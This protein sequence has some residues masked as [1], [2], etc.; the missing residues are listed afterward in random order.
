MEIPAG[1]P[2]CDGRRAGPQVATVPVVGYLRRHLLDGFLVVLAVAEV[3]VL[4]AG[5]GPHRFAAAGLAAAGALL[6]LARRRWPLLIS[7]LALGALSG[8][9]M[10]AVP[11]PFF[12]FFALMAT[13]AV[14]A[15]VNS[16][17]DGVIAWAVG[18]VL[19]LIATRVADHGGWLAD[20]L[21]TLAFCTIMWIAGWLVSTRTRQVE[22]MAL[23]A[24]AAEHAR[25]VALREERARI[26]R[27]LH[28]VV[29]HGLSVVVV[30][31]LAA[32]SAV[33]D[34][35]REG[36]G[37]VTRHLDAIEVTARE[38]LWEMRRML[39]LLQVD[40]LDEAAAADPS[41]GLR[42]ID[43]L[44]DR[45]RAGGVVV[46]ACRVD[47]DIRVSAGLE[48][49]IYRVVQE[50]LTNCVKHAPGSHV[51]VQVRE[52]AGQVR[53]DVVDD[54]GPDRGAGPF[55]LGAGHGLLGMAERVTLY[56]GELATGPR[57]GGGFG[58]QASFPADLP[59]AAT[60]SPHRTPA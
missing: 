57:G 21:L 38:A 26:A 31:T 44:V 34:V 24:E 15:A 48:M 11:I 45:A 13:F 52:Q 23:R 6:L 29:S 43:A 47:Q 51:E 18:A 60:A 17:R 59:A 12:L 58:I 4:V 25:Y 19:L 54:G 35:A 41:H 14:V 50:A 49:S 53:I 16:T 8:A 40:D 39:G 28:D 1:G 7:I 3:S 32:R 22:L 20:G 2:P 33:D 42:D 5:D 9:L 27:E 10:L 46:D 56:G 55:A 37:E 30:Q 36:P